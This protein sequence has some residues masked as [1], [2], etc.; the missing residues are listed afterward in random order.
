MK[1]RKEWHIEVGE[2]YSS[3]V[4]DGRQIYLHSRQ[5]TNEVIRCI[6][7]DSGNIIWSNEYR[8]AGRVHQA[9]A[10]HGIGPKSTPCVVDARL[11]TLGIGSILSCFD[12]KS[13]KLLWRKQYEGQFP[14]PAP[15]CGTSMSPLVTDGLCIV[16]V[17]VDRQGALI[18][19]DTES[20]IERWRYEGDGPGYGSPI[21]TALAGHRQLISPVS[22]F[23]AGFSID[24]GKQLWRF[25]FPTRSTQNIITPVSD[26]RSIVVGGI[27]QITAKLVAGDKPEV[28]WDNRNWSM[29]MSSPIQ[30]GERIIGTSTRD[31]GVIFCLDAK[32]GKLIWRSEDG[33]SRHVTLTRLGNEVAALTQHGRLILF[34]PDHEKLEPLASYD[35]TEKST[36]A[37]PLFLGRRIF[38][39]DN[40]SLTAWRLD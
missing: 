2:G 1:L 11:F 19:Y 13:G 12:T 40:T 7:W 30:V 23:I 22:K 8:A 25:P 37:N 31:R 9:G 36:W 32:T 24:T 29:H 33:M 18:A 39:K 17:G 27:A 16:H 5:G 6:A 34:R 26:G 21:V 10:D 28:L 14:R 35:V 3:P 38:I 15:S 20:G 4:T